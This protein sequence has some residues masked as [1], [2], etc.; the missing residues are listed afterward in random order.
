MKRVGIVTTV[1]LCCLTS[2]AKQV[3]LRPRHD[4]AALKKRY[5]EFV[6]SLDYVAVARDYRKAVENLLSGDPERQTVALRTLSE[7][8]EPRVIPWMVPFLDT[9]DRT[10]RVW[11]GVSIQKVI[12]TC[13]LRRRDMSRL[14]KV[15][16]KPLAEGDTDLRPFAWIALKMFRKDDD[17]NTHANATTIT[18]YLELR[19]FEGELR[20]CLRSRHPAVRDKAL[21]ALESLGFTVEKE[22]TRQERGSDANDP[23]R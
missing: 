16:V 15:V 9:E 23:R 21:W 3:S 13:A 14:G 11:A 2:S 17:G 18:R 10:V 4:E 12:S 1:V 19:E 7:T 6:S 22:D 5:V 20:R 8:G